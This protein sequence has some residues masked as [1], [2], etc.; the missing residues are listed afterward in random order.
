MP[1]KT[2]AKA[3]MFL[4]PA[5]RSKA[6]SCMSVLQFLALCDNKKYCYPTAQKSLWV[7]CAMQISFFFLHTIRSRVSCLFSYTYIA[8]CVCFC[9]FTWQNDSAIGKNTTKVPVEKLRSE[10]VCTAWLDR[11]IEGCN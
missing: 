6:K 8:L 7:F 5:M 10:C 2:F 3:H 4:F 1:G 11:V 9:A